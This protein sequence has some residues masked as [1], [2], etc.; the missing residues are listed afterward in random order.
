M[1]GSR[2][3]LSLAQYLD[4]LGRSFLDLI[5]EKHGLADA[6]VSWREY[7]SAPLDALVHVLRDAPPDRAQ[8]LVEEI[9]ATEPDLY[10]RAVDKWGNGALAYRAR[11]EDLLQCLALD[12]YAVVG[13]RLAAVEPDLEGA[14]H[15]EDALAAEIR[16]SGLPGAESIVAL[17]QKSADVFRQSRQTT[18]APSSTRGRRCKRWLQKSPSPGGRR[19]GGTSRRTSGARYWITCGRRDSSRHRR[20]SSSPLSTR[21]SAP[22]LITTSGSR[23]RRWSASVA[24]WLSPSATSSS[25]FTMAEGCRAVERAR[26]EQAIFWVFAKVAGLPIRKKS[27]QSRPTPEPDIL[28]TVDGD[29]VAFELGEVVYAQFAETTFQ[30]QPLR[31]RFREEYVK[32]AAPIRSQLEE[33]LGGPPVVSVWFP[34]GTSP[35]DWRRAIPGILAV[36]SQRAGEVVHGQS[37]PVWKN[38]DLKGVVLEM[39][40][41]RG[42]RAALHVVELTEVRDQTLDLLKKKFGR[43]YQT[44][45]PIELVAYYISQPPPRHDGWVEEVASFITQHLGETPFRRVWLFNHFSGGSIPLVVP[46]YDRRS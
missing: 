38:P 10:E 7:A 44:S 42:Q 15:V 40:V 29:P 18:T 24:A 23:K 45:A 9:V 20:K 5:F 25:S 36:L 26:G 12:G 39:E 35:G 33:R 22:A 21:P 17:L 2:T 6:W 8:G 41:R 46:P 30:R 34:D 27:I 4:R 28:C 37:L 16:R 3:R 11:W 1:I 14:N 19:T 43:T 13:R 32:L 31:Q